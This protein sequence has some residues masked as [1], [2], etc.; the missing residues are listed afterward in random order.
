MEPCGT[1]IFEIPFDWIRDENSANRF[2]FLANFLIGN[3][4]TSFKIMIHGDRKIAWEHFI[5]ENEASSRLESGVDIA[6][7]LIASFENEM[8]RPVSRH[9]VERS[10]L[11]WKFG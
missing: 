2:V 1:E 3:A 6:E 9:H 4:A 7:I 10:V 11:G 5:G 8:E